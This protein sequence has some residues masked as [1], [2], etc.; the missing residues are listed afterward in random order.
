MTPQVPQ[1]E[2]SLHLETR[3]V[4]L[5][6]PLKFKKKVDDKWGYMDETGNFAILPKFNEAGHFS[7]PERPFRLRDF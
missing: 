4:V 2:S 6:E 3:L 5:C 7:L 1:R